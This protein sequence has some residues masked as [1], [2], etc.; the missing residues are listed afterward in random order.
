MIT[1]LLYVALFWNALVA[2]RHPWT[3]IVLAYLMA[4]LTPQT[5]WWW[6]FE[7][8]RPFYWTIVPALL[9]FLFAMMRGQLD[10]APLK[11]P[12]NRCLALLW[13]CFTVAYYFGP[14][15]GVINKWR[16]YDADLMF[17][18]L[19][20]TYLTYFIATILITGPKRLGIASLVMVVT[21]A[22]M[23]Y[24]A[25]AQYFSYHKYGRLHGPT[26]LD[27]QGIYADENDFAVLFVV[28]FPF[29]FY[30]GQYL[31][32]K[33]GRYAVWLVIPFSWHAIFLTASRGALV[34]VGAVLAVFAL[35]LKSKWMGI[36]LI[37]AFVAAFSLEAGDVM[38]NRS[39][40]IAE[41]ESEDSASA[42]LDA[43]AAATGMM[44]AHPLT[45]VGFASMGQAFPDYSDKR[46][47]VA[48][49]TFFQIGAEWG[50]IAAITFLVLMLSTLRALAKNGTRLRQLPDSDEVRLH[51]L[52]NEACLLGMA[53][54]FVCS[55]FLSLQG[56]E[57][58]Y[59]L[60]LL[61]GG[62]LF[63]SGYYRQAAKSAGRLG[64]RY[65]VGRRIG[66][67]IPRVQA[68]DRLELVAPEGRPCR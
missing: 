52:L 66:P 25:N 62:T 11:T 36:A 22:Y 10:Y 60:L 42:R 1:A 50:V 48:H 46:P 55:M 40:T 12:T 49:N 20:K 58:L 68:G 28:G 59:F 26:T 33:V 13:L 45:G 29:L 47:R 6:A 64:N 57:V 61:S 21:A 9:G 35:R 24:W 2:L 37:V 51:Y 43:W 16:F 38:K 18:T 23:T 3:G 32:G 5:I 7:G 17:A 27:G 41:Y 34:G 44:L 53:G 56:Y 63:S 8:V 15:V 30:F 54:F 67:Q 4:V 14:Y 19:Q 31:R 39:A 65:G